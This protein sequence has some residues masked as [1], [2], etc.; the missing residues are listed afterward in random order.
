MV[1]A[2]V[3]VT[4]DCHVQLALCKTALSVCEEFLHYECANTISLSP[5]S[6]T[7]MHSIILIRLV[8]TACWMICHPMFYYTLSVYNRCEIIIFSLCPLCIRETR[9]FHAT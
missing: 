2:F 8:V 4:P 9:H 5:Q 1:E 6:S 7:H 3:C